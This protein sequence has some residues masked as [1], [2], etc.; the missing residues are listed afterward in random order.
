M[1]RK[2]EYVIL[3]LLTTEGRQSQLSPSPWLQEG[4]QPYPYH[5]GKNCY[6]LLSR[7]WS[8]YEKIPKSTDYRESPTC[9][10]DHPTVRLKGYKPHA[11]IPGFS[12][13]FSSKPFDHEQIVKTKKWTKEPLTLEIQNQNRKK[14]KKTNLEETDITQENENCKSFKGIR[15][16]NHETRFCEKRIFRD[17]KKLF[18]GQKMMQTAKICRRV[19]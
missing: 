1:T 17:H 2:R 12:W 19:G 3:Y 16:C 7:I 14:K 18:K 15:C 9:H 13:A 5:L 4:W 10:P 6:P 11:R 8:A